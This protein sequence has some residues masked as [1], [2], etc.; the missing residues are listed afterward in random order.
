MT[1]G[2]QTAELSDDVYA[3]IQTKDF[4]MKL[5]ESELKTDGQHRKRCLTPLIFPPLIFPGDTQPAKVSDAVQGKGFK[6]QISHVIERNRIKNRRTNQ[7]MRNPA[8]LVVM[9]FLGLCLQAVWAAESRP[10]IIFIL[11]DDQ[12]DDS[13]SGM[14]HAWVKTPHIDTLL[15]QGVR[16]EN[17]YIAEPTCNPSRA[18][19]LLGCHERVNRQGFCSLHKM[20]Q[21]QWN[22]SYPALLQKAGYKTGFVGKWHVYT[23]LEIE[24]LFDYWDGRIGHGPFYYET[25]DADGKKQTITCNRKHTNSALKFLDEASADT[26]FCL[27]LCY[28]TPHGSKVVMMNEVLNESASNDPRLKDHPIYG[29]LYGGRYRNID[30]PYP[31][32]NPENPYD[33]IPKN[34]MDQDMGRSN[35]YRY[36]YDP[37][38]NKEHHSRYYQLITEIDQ[39]VG[40]LA[41]GLKTR[42]LADNTIIVFGSDHGLLMGEY[43]MGGKALLYDLT[44]KIPCF[45]YDPST[46][47]KL[48]GTSRKELVSSL[49]LTVT[50][51]DYAGV[52]PGKFMTGRSLKP[53]VRQEKLKTPWREG[54]FLE[55]MYTGRDTP[56][57]EGYVDGEWK[58]IRFFKVPRR[59][60]DDDV[61]T[62]G[63]TPVLESLFSLTNDPLE[64]NNLANNA[65]YRKKLCELRKKCDADLKDLL[66]QRKKYAKQHDISSAKN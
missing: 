3:R 18:A 14:G 17:T 29:G 64:K 44:S 50:I 42:G 47:E 51:L 60:S 12:R 49:D 36:D 6:W 23:E 19:L 41:A 53:L 26:P 61:E 62:A 59:Y 8:K 48:R 34:V 20:N 1:S 38:M 55:N 58:Y 39:M 54:L 43:G 24:S 16:F 33:F 66:K 35:L 37:V 11:T 27:S 32:Q 45:V 4:Q 52:A 10:N 2:A 13:F 46:P 65:E 57:Q 22:Q 9:I 15:S 56:L 28:A 63:R 31:L 40:E 30:I 7:Q 21:S 25:T 5:N